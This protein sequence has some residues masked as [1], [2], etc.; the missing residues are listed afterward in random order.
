VAEESV[1]V[2]Q[3]KQKRVVWFT[4][5][6]R[7]LVLNKTNDRTIRG[8]FGDA[9]DGWNGKIVI[10]FPTKVDMRGKL[11]PALRLRIP[12]PKQESVTTTAA[13]M[14]APLGNGAVT[15]KPPP[16]EQASVTA[17]ADPEIDDDP[18]TSLGDESDNEIRF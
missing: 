13:P 3:K 11:V 17:H 2:E 1:G 12:P 6:E 15:A 7:G 14:P 16:T 4:N 8:A 18:P 10:V 9:V 5:D